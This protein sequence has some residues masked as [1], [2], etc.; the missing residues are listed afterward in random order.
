[1]RNPIIMKILAGV[2]FSLLMSGPAYSTDGQYPDQPKVRTDYRS[3]PDLGGW[4]EPTN[5]PSENE[6]DKNPKEYPDQP[7]VPTEY[8]PS[9]DPGGWGEEK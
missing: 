5:R 1:M 8:R 9:M 2:A 3:S 4:A 6:R 7:K